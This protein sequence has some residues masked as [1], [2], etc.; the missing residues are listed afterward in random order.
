MHSQGVALRT[1][2]DLLRNRTI[3][4][5]IGLM[6]NVGTNY[7]CV[8][9]SCFGWN[10]VSNKAA[11][12]PTFVLSRLDSIPWNYKSPCNSGKVANLTPYPPGS[13]STYC[14]SYETGMLKGQHIAINF[15]FVFYFLVGWVCIHEYD[16]VHMC[17]FRE[18]LGF[19]SLL[20]PWGSQESSLGH[21]ACWGAPSYLT[22]P[23]LRKTRVLWY[24]EKLSHIWQLKGILLS[25]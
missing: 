1:E 6:E 23:G 7:L 4:K 3:A 21:Q 12:T 16:T 2:S 17:R 18:L 20:P 5:V 22:S 15:T 24:P 14:L 8:L 9:K 10:A 11:A 13:K 25:C 19:C